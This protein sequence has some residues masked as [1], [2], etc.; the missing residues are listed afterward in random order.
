MRPADLPGLIINCPRLSELNI[1]HYKDMSPYRQLDDNLRWVYPK[2]LFDGLSMPTSSWPTIRL[3]SWLW[4]ARMM[5]KDEWSFAD[6]KRIHLLPTFSV[7]RK[8]VLVN[9]QRPSLRAPDDSDPQV[10]DQDKRY[11]EVL[12][13][14]LDVL[15]DLKHLVMESST[16]ANEML[17]PLLPKT[18]QHL[19][20]INCWD[21]TADHFADYL[22]SHGRKLRHLTLHHNQSLSLSFLPVLRDS[23]PELQSLRMNLT[24]Y[25]HHEFYK[26]SNPM[27]DTLLAADEVPT[28][29]SPLRV[30]E[31]EHLR[32]WD[33][34]AAEVFFQSLVDGAPRLPMLR[35]LAIKAN[36]NIPWRQRSEMRDKWVARL[37]KVF[38]RQS[39]APR[40]A[41]TLQAARCEDDHPPPPTKRPQRN[42]KDTRPE[43]RSGRIASLV[44]G[45]SPPANGVPRHPR[46]PGRGV[47]SYKEPDSDEE[48]D[49]DEEDGDGT[50]DDEDSHAST[51][52]EATGLVQR[53][54]DI[55]AIRFD[56]Q[57]PTE[58]QYGMDDFLDSDHAN[59]DDEWAGDDDGLEGTD[60]AW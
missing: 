43:R 21:V 14:L 19:E 31:L 1:C 6:I 40:P 22:L 3:R 17:L 34:E 37:G 12:A 25:K 32:Q 49:D 10:I 8:I 9:Y 60:Y 20:L 36:L 27:Y 57:K 39:A 38:K 26:D 55:V 35:H 47:V 7:L 11:V 15:P 13:S 52:S 5:G 58:M 24:Y 18:L 45:T 46:K 2:A 28:W 4:S 44:P 50:S 51:I 54:C 29:P 42:G 41:R 23:C 16:A 53:L 30:I 56:N 33:A 48:I 59:S